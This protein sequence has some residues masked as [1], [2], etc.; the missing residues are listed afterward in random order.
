M[1]DKIIPTYV[2]AA[3]TPNPT[4]MKFVADRPII[5]NGYKAEYGTASE[6]MGKSD[7]AVQLFN[8]PFVEQVFVSSNFVTVA[9]NNSIEWEDIQNELREFI[10]KFLMQNELAVT[11]HEELPVPGQDNQKEEPIG[12]AAPTSDDDKEIIT[13][14]DEYVRPAVEGDGG[15]IDF[16][17]Y[18]D[19]VVTVALR[20]AC[21]GCPSST[22]TLKG[23]IENLL[24]SK[25]S[26]VKEVVAEAL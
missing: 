16:R 7:L 24:K 12:H 23:G 11:H 18:H 5:T 8:F 25:M 17:S 20:G 21:S 9:K 1:S 14:L 6:A 15:A 4:N 19:G 26:G 10:S 13:L 3:A 22:Q 2:Y